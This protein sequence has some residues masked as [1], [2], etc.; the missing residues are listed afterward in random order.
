MLAISQLLHV[1]TLSSVT[2]ADCLRR[3]IVPAPECLQDTLLELKVFAF[4]E[5]DEDA[6]AAISALAALQV[7]AL[8]AKRWGFC[9]SVIPLRFCSYWQLGFSTSFFFAQTLRLGFGYSSVTAAKRAVLVMPDLSKLATSLKTVAVCAPCQVH[10]DSL[11]SLERLEQVSIEHRPQTG[12]PFPS[13][14]AS[15]QTLQRVTV[16]C[17][18]RHLY[19]RTSSLC[20][21]A[22]EHCKSA[23]S[24]LLAS[25][26]TR[27]DLT[28][29]PPEHLFR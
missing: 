1:F 2:R 23:F 15:A 20:D 4:D 6:V 14:L 29:G 26:E 28:F 7:C 13:L 19:G 12:A 24:E 25:T 10:M 16:K 27:E 17:S 11:T 8:G 22:R 21:H 18:R 5:R 9:Q 3:A